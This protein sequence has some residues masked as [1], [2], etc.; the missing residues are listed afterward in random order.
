MVKKSIIPFEWRKIMFQASL[1]FAAL[2][3]F[4]AATGFLLLKLY[5]ANPA[6][7]GKLMNYLLLGILAVGLSTVAVLIGLRTEQ[8][9]STRYS[10]NLREVQKIWG[11]AIIQAP[12][13]LSYRQLT[14][15]E[16]HHWQTGKPYAATKTIRRDIKIW[17]AKIMAKVNRDIRARGL[18]VYNGYRLTF[19]GTWHIKNLLRHKKEIYFHLPLPTGGNNIHDAV[20]TAGAK[21]YHGDHRVA[22]GLDWKGTL[23]PGETRTIKITYRC[24]GLDTFSYALDTQVREI[25]AF[26]FTIDT[27]F[28]EKIINYRDNSMVHS[29]IREKKERRHIIWKG[30]N[31]ITRQPIA[32]SFNSGKKPWEIVANLYYYAPLAIFL[33]LAVLLVFSLAYNIRL[34]FMHFL[35]FGAG[36]IFFHLFLSYIVSYTGFIAGFIISSI[37]SGGMILFYAR[38]LN[39][40]RRLLEGTL[41]GL[42]MFQL[43]FSLAF[44]FPAYTGLLILI[45]SAMT[46]TIIMKATAG[47]EWEGRF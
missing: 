16:R 33:F 15:V 45:G 24:Q 5:Q 37:I 13:A 9:G 29:L 8:R 21:T 47:I 22:D 39:R 4:I 19:T 14:R 1:A 40:G 7:L 12:P 10:Q 35:F 18:Q 11:G 3:A 26:S 25:P 41:I 20:I 42:A 32:L 6:F 44:Y 34:H 31:L 23:A 17:R 46:L 2:L 28:P 43:F 30:K 27:D 36:F 38:Q